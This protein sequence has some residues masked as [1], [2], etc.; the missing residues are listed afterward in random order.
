MLQ[1]LNGDALID[2]R[3]TGLIL[4]SLWNDPIQPESNI[5]IRS[6]SSGEAVV[7]IPVDNRKA[8][9]VRTVPPIS[10][11]AQLKRCN[12]DIDGDIRLVGDGPQSATVFYVRGET[13]TICSAMEII[14]DQIRFDGSAWFEAE[15]IS[16]PPRIRIHVVNGTKIGWGGQFATHYP[17]NDVSPSLPPPYG[18]IADDPLSVLVRECAWRLASAGSL[19]LNPDLSVPVD[20]R[21][22]NWIRRQ[23]ARE[24]PLLVNLMIEHKLASS[25]SMEASGK[26]KIRL[27]LACTWA[28]LRDALDN[29][30]RAPH[31][32]NFVREARRSLAAL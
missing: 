9:T 10:F 3:Y 16:F 11:Y 6:E 21:R 31:L 20:D 15:E 14:A 5:E 27:R 2:G 24:F 22:V 28:D 4:N 30:E 29:P 23:F 25:E 19:T 8:L 17:W 18:I 13:T 26:G 1:R 7:H 32:E 12:A